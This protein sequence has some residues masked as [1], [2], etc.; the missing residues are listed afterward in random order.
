MSLSHFNPSLFHFNTHVLLKSCDVGWSFTLLLM[1][2][3]SWK[4]I[5]FFLLTNIVIWCRLE[6]A[7]MMSFEAIFFSLVEICA[8]PTLRTSTQ[9]KLCL[10]ELFPLSSVHSCLTGLFLWCVFWLETSTLSTFCHRHFAHAAICQ[11]GYRSP[12]TGKVPISSYGSF[13]II[14]FEGR[15]GA[16]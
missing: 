10:P 7:A 9:T 6:Y 5:K 12:V 3:F 8:G 14:H 4:R 11:R 13:H 1:S 16:V 2:A 15:S